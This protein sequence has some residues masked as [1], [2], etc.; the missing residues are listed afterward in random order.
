M[1]LGVGQWHGANQRSNSSS[2]LPSA[3]SV[4]VSPLFSS[5]RDGADS[6]CAGRPGNF[7]VAELKPKSA[8][9]VFSAAHLPAPGSDSGLRL[10]LPPRPAV[11]LAPRDY[12]SPH[13]LGGRR[14]RLLHARLCF[15]FSMQASGLC[16]SFAIYIGEH[17]YRRCWI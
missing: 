3:L 10:S 8:Q 1:V 12:S 4:V 7:V 5:L 2:L 15:A 16:I 9:R 17:A 11:A 6:V 13:P 14:S